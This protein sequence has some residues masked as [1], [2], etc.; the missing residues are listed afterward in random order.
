MK[1]S[2]INQVIKDMETLIK[3]HGFEMPPFARWTAEE[4]NSIGHEYDEIRDN[5]LG[6]DITDFGLGK[7]DEVGFSLFTIRNGNPKLDKYKKTYAEKLLMLYEGQTAAMHFHASKMEDIINRGG[8]D[9]YITVY[10]GTKDEEMLDTDVTVYSDGRHTIVPAGT[11]VLL[12]PG[13]SITIMPY[14][15]HDFIVPETGGSVLLG[16]VSMC[17]DDDNDNFF[18]NKSIGRFPEIEEDEAPYRLLCN[19]Y[20][21]AGT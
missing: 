17:N 4:W 6:W 7:F 12:K 16:E 21:K 8:N 1:R 5:K 11:K 20:P 13:E 19:E 2:R 3:E 9:V 14:M 18:Y 10:N 15:Y